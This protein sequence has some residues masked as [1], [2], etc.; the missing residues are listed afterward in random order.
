MLR[1]QSN[2]CLGPDHFA[3]I[4]SKRNTIAPTAMGLTLP[5]QL[6]K[7]YYLVIPYPFLPEKLKN[8]RKWKWGQGFET[9]EHKKIPVFTDHCIFLVSLYSLHFQLEKWSSVQIFQRLDEGFLGCPTLSTF[10][11]LKTCLNKW[12]FVPQNQKNYLKLWKLASLRGKL[13][14]LVFGATVF[15][16]TVFSLRRFFP[17]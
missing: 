6:P 1:G 17:S 7:L 14:F 10:H 5:H 11:R 3:V 4:I 16:K 15:C 2:R 12:L 13:L 8:C 9:D